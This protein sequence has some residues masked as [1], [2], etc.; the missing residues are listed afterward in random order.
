MVFLKKVLTC[1]YSG[2]NNQTSP[3]DDVI[4]MDFEIDNATGKEDREVVQHKKR[5]NRD[6]PH[7]SGFGRLE[8]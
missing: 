7:G 5:Q 4:Q 2:R 3:E 6:K 8:L 1:I